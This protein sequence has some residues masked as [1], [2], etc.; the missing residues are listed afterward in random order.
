MGHLWTRLFKHR[1]VRILL[2]GECSSPHANLYISMLIAVFSYGRTVLSILLLLL[3]ILLDSLSPASAS[4]LPCSDVPWDA[5]RFS[6]T[7]NPV[8]PSPPTPTPHF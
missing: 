1:D 8:P 2:L 4:L 6:T 7:G 3:L 5:E